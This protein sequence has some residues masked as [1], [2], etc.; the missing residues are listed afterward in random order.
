MK[1]R[2]TVHVAP[3][4]DTMTVDFHDAQVYA[5][6]DRW[7][8]ARGDV[9]AN[10]RLTTSLPAMGPILHESRWN[11]S[12]TT[13]R[14]EIARSLRRRYEGLDWLDLLH[15]LAI[16]AL[17]RRRVGEPVVMAGRLPAT[18]GPRYL[19]DPLVLRDELNLLYGAGGTGKSF[20]AI[21][22]A[23]AIQE[24]WSALGPGVPLDTH[25]P[26]LYL[27]FETSP[28]EIDSRVKMIAAGAHASPVP[29]LAVKRC[30]GALADQVDDLRRVVAQVRAKFVVVDSA[31]AACAGEPESAEVTL[32]LTNAIR[33]LRVTALL[34]DHLPKEGEDPFGSVYKI[35]AAR[36]VWR[37]RREQQ[38][39]THEITVGLWHRKTN[40]S[41][42]HKPL[43][44]TLAFS[45]V[46]DRVRFTRADLTAVESFRETLPLRDL[47][48]G[49]LLAEG[50]ASMKQIAD[51]LGK[52]Y[53]AV[54]MALK[55]M[56]GKGVTRLPSEAPGDEVRWGIPSPHVSSQSRP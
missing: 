36:N 15:A 4:G 23:L 27:D 47:I 18:A 41:H 29:E 6:L 55:R 34:I 9:W 31:G 7:R 10:L 46:G 24:P 53:D 38:E 32:R 12:S 48:R 25:V 21:A 17:D 5:T 51:A 42:L 44:F 43:G 40:A 56:D 20:L 49:Y 13:H 30:S 39:G 35:N 45:E 8:E 54:R 19:L 52:P 26:G 22:V 16:L 1:S 33:A 37:I 14:E 3:D 11:L 2:A 50:A 28:Q